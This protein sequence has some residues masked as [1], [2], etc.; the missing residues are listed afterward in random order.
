MHICVHIGRGSKTMCEHCVTNLILHAQTHHTTH[1]HTYSFDRS[2]YSTFMLT[3]LLRDWLR[4][5]C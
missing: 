5:C 2:L 1:T 3:S 4:I